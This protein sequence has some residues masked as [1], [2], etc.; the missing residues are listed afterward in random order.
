MEE[1]EAK[2]QLLE[3]LGLLAPLKEGGVTHRVIQVA[4][5]QVGSQTLQHS[6]QF[7]T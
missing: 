2:Q 4:L 7:S 1:A 3:G 5:Q 6:V